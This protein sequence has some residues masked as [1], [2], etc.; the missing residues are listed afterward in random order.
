M[1]TVFKSWYKIPSAMRTWH[2]TLVIS[3]LRW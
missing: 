1:S 3:L 2:Y